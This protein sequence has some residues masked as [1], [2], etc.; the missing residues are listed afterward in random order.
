MGEVKRYGPC[1]YTISLSEQVN[2]SLVNYSDY[3]AM[4]AKLA[5]SEAACAAKDGWMDA[6]GAVEATCFSHCEV[7][8]RAPFETYRDVGRVEVPK[9]WAGSRV[10]IVRKP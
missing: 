8:G 3:A 2:G 5:A 1:G 9:E 7:V 6:A 10:L 4:E